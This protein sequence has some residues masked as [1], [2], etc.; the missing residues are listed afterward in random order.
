MWVWIFSAPSQDDSDVKKGNWI[1]LEFNLFSIFSFKPCHG[2]NPINLWFPL[3]L[4]ELCQSLELQLVPSIGR[5]QSVSVSLVQLASTEMSITLWSWVNS[6]HGLNQINSIPMVLFQ[7]SLLLLCP[8]WMHRNLS[9]LL[10]P[11]IRH[12]KFCWR[13]HLP[14]HFMQPFP[15]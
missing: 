1:F 7:V 6:P 2:Q 8:F 14:R 4:L 10:R 13:L 11:L 9:A 3:I 15:L 12:K 5:E